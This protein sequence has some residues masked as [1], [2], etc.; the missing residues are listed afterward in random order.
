MS[1][2]NR[3]NSKI[4]GIK[5]FEWN[6]VVLLFVLSAF[7]CIPAFAQ[8]TLCMPGSATPSTLQ[9]YILPEDTVALPWTNETPIGLRSTETVDNVTAMRADLTH[10]APIAFDSNGYDSAADFDF[11]EFN[12]RSSIDNPPIN[13]IAANGSPCGLRE[14]VDIKSNQWTQVQVPLASLGL[15]GKA[16]IGRLKLKSTI[17]GQFT[18]WINNV[19]LFSSTG[20]LPDFPPPDDPEE[21]PIDEPPLPEV[22]RF[23]PWHIDPGVRD[24]IDNQLPAK[25]VV[26]NA[27]GQDQF[28]DTASF[29]AALDAI[30]TGGIIEIPPGTYYLSD[31]IRLT[32]DRQVIRGAGSDLTHLVFTES[33]PFGIAIT[34]QYPQ[35]PTPV[36][37]G[38]YRGSSLLVAPNSDATSGRYGLLTDS[39]S[40]RSQVVSIVGREAS[41]NNT[42]LLLA[43]PLNSD[44]TGTASLQVFDANEFSGVEAL[45][46]DVVSNNTHVGDMVHMRSA[47][48]VWLRDVLSKRARQSHV[49]T[50]Q[51]YHCEITGNT[52]LDAT[53]HGDGKQG[54][55]IDLANSTTGCLVENNTLGYL[56]H[57]ILF[58]ASANGNIVAF[59]HSFSPRH[60]NFANGGPGDIS[61][62]S[63][64]YANLVEGNV[65]ERI[66]IGDAGP[67]GEGNLIHR[68]CV[69]SGPLTI[70]NSPD[71]IQSFYSNAVYGSDIQLQNT[72]MPPVL[73]ETPLPRSYIQ[74][75]T[76]LFDED[77]VNVNAI[78]RTPSL[79]NNWYKG[80]LRPTAETTP[81]S[82]YGT[83]YEPLLS[84]SITGSWQRDCR[85]P[86]A[87]NMAD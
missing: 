79:K 15:S 46:M 22:T 21:P 55:G 59:N 83:R 56:R 8:T 58:N 1:I 31:S 76:V 50:R 40:A 65:V 29:V 78:A 30:A 13:I 60:T 62:H 39:N 36:I 2:G 75:G 32:R 64:A 42:R 24:T 47:A 51:S 49:F 77:G 80:Q 45:S 72:F 28:D 53:G 19:R 35:A 6:Q 26:L 70:D 82:Y 38:E 25:R 69:T 57:S 87:G 63:F 9:N 66:H 68:N 71:A 3:S 27:N 86:A 4:G 33:L 5:K 61:F 81:L 11:I 20:T 73:P 44:F 84:A 17:A 54:Y 7:Y 10:W 18:L 14:F 43:N 34:G 37:N 48:H 85:I 74:S 23:V 52:M 41:Q 67:V 12:L 16:S